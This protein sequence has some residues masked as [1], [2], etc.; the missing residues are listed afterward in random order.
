MPEEQ[1]ILLGATSG[2]IIVIVFLILHLKKLKRKLKSHI[3]RKDQM[4]KY[5]EER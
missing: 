3:L 5:L 1:I 2:T 4:E